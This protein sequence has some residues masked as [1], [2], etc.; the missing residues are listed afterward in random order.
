MTDDTSR[1]AEMV[2][3]RTFE[4]MYGTVQRSYCPY[5]ISV[6]ESTFKCYLFTKHHIS[7]LVFATRMI[8][9][10]FFLNIQFQASSGLCRTCSETTLLVLS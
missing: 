4:M 5:T 2:G 1:K 10:L 6:S 7:T 8:Q 3:C 9:F